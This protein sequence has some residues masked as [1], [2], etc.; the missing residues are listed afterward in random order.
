MLVRLRLVLASL[1]SGAL[2]LL[3]LCLGGQNLE[4][5]PKL[6]VGAGSTA[7]LPA[8]FLVG[9]ALVAGVVSGGCSAALLWPGG[10]GERL[11]G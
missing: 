2:L 10:S 6:W 11:E 5:R 1:S 3:L 8:G 7:P 4:Q 9:L